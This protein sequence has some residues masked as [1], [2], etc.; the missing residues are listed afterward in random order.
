MSAK[1]DGVR[2]NRPVLL[3]VAQKGYQCQSAVDQSSYQNGN[4]VEPAIHTVSLEH[5]LLYLGVVLV[6]LTLLVFRR[7]DVG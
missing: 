4:A 7:R 5:G 2:T 1:D 3:A 6:A